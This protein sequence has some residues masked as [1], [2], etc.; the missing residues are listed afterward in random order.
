MKGGLDVVVDEC[1]VCD[2]LSKS[3]FNEEIYGGFMAYD[4]FDGPVKGFFLFLFYFISYSSFLNCL[5][6]FFL[7]PLVTTQKKERKNIENETIYEIVYLAEDSNGYQANISRFWRYQINDISM[8]VREL[9]SFQQQMSQL[10]FK[11]LVGMTTLLVG[12]GTVFL[13]SRLKFAP[14]V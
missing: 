10:F 1:R 8:S 14:Q 2:R 12:V 6:H 3:P 13:F 4:F 7:L 5:S 11:V 9:I